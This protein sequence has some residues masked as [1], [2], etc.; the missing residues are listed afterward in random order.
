MRE[1]RSGRRRR[2]AARAREAEVYAALSLGTRDYVREERLRP[3]RDR[4]L[5]RD[6]LHA[7]G[8]DR[9]RRARARPRD[10]RRACRRA[11]PPRARKDDARALAE[12]LGVEF[13]EI[14]IATAMEVYEAAARRALRGP[15]AR[16]HRGEPPGAHPRQPADG[17][18]EQVRLARAHD[19]QQV[20]DLG[21]LLDALRRHRRRLRGHQGRARRRSSTGSSTSATRATTA[22]SGPAVDHRPPAE[23]RAAPGPEGRGLA[24]RLRHARPRSSRPTSRRTPTASSSPLPACPRRPST[25]C[26]RSSTARSTS[27]ARRRR[28]SRSRR[29]RSGATGGCRSPTATAG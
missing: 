17:A 28:A 16:H 12:S 18:L 15:R 13:L 22:A 7:G 27:A 3:R 23:R 26:S 25:A 24:A 9:G 19:R 10:V 1:A 20:R 21:R 6:R 11:T 8:A 29:A 2:R 4:P 14:P 5:G